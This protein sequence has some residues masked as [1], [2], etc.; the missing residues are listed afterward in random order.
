MLEHKMRCQMK[1]GGIEIGLIERLEFIFAEVVLKIN[2][3]TECHVDLTNCLV[4]LLSQ[5]ACDG[6][7]RE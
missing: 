1:C 4:A 6:E 5:H 2:G 7:H 3:L